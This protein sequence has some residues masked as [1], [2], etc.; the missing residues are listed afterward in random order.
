M[1]NI[2]LLFLTALSLITVS[3][4]AQ[5]TENKKTEKV[6]F[7]C[8]MHADITSDKAG[9]CSKCGMDLTKS[10]KEKMKMEMET[11]KIYS[12]PM[13]PEVT[14]DKASTCSKCGMNLKEKK[15]KTSE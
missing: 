7:S 5:S 9:A 12:C 8:P 10:K 2:K 4:F 11:M 14:S 15:G 13:H 1:K 6:K 3:L